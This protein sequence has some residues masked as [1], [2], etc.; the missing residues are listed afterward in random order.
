MAKN[1]SVQVNFEV[2][3]ALNV[4]CKF[5]T[6]VVEVLADDRLVTDLEKRI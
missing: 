4:A 3:L 1:V 5:D 2:G 6:G